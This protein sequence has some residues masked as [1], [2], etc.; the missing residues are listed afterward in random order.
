MRNLTQRFESHWGKARSGV[1][2]RS[3]VQLD[4]TNSGLGLFTLCGAALSVG[5]GIHSVS[6]S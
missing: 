6:A 4:Q 3:K 5:V 2:G 1:L